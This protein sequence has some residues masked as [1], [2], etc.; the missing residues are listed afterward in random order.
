MGLSRKRQRELKRLKNSAGE[1]WGDQKDLL[2]HAS[3]VVREATRQAANFAREEVAPRARETFDE[4]VRP[5]VASGL[6]S[7]VAGARS[8][9]HA[10]RERI[11][12]EVFPAVS[13]A[14]AN[15][16]A[17]LEVA[18]DPRVREVIR[19]V[20]STGASAASKVGIAQ[21]KKSS[22]PGKYILIGVGVVALAGIAYAAW[23]TL[24]ADD[25]LWIDDDESPEVE[26]PATD[27]TSDPTP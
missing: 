4:R 13:G 16:L 20:T 22:G 12:D 26:G 6:A 1:L 5:A 11:S 15:A 25:D 8:V 18:K 3:H 27:T 17:L 2:E 9:A 7:G 21:P 14:L 23:Q 10:G 19:K 24:R